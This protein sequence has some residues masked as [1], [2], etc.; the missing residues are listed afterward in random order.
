MFQ[1]IYFININNPLLSSPLNPQ[2]WTALLCCNGSHIWNR[3]KSFNACYIVVIYSKN[4]RYCT[5]CIEKEKNKTINQP[6]IQYNK[7]TQ[8]DHCGFVT[9]CE[10][11]CCRNISHYRRILIFPP[12]CKPPDVLCLRI[13]LSEYPGFMVSCF[14]NILTNIQPY[15]EA[16]DTKSINW[17]QAFISCLDSINDW[18]TIMW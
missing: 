12:R 9:N 18:L 16:T 14:I 11:G 15:S 2:H 4:F 3:A 8:R 13:S 17:K 10:R 7:N 5:F 1:F 6:R